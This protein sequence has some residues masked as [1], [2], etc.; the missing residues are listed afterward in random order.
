[1]YDDYPDWAVY[2]NALKCMYK[3]NPITIDIAGTVESIKKIDKEVL[4]KC[5]NTFYN[6]SNMLMCFVGDFVPEELLKEIKSRLVE[7]K[8]QGEIKR[9]Y[10]EEQE[11]IV[12]QKEEQIMDVSQPLFVIGIKDI[13]DKENI[14]KKHIAVEILLNM[15]IGKSSRLYKELYEAELLTAEPYLEYEF[16]ENYAHVMITGNSKDPEKVLEKINEEIEK[17]KLEGINDQD[18]ERIKNMLYGNTVKEFNSASEIA[19]MFV[20]DYF[21]GINSF[22]Y[23]EEYKQIKKEYVEQILSET[24]NKEKTGSDDGTFLDEYFVY[25]KKK[26]LSQGKF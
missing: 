4:Y 15:I 10:E 25:F 16:G 13:L 1:M 12:K 8:A 11:E 24:F 20:T 22:D 17:I 18:F 14:V 2:M 7:K 9:I 19:K 3:V 6:P 5:Y 21:R 26:G 23:L